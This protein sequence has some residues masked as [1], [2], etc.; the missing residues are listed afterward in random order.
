MKGIVSLAM[1]VF[2]LSCAQ[3]GVILPLYASTW[4]EFSVEWS[5]RE[6]CAADSKIAPILDQVRSGLQSSGSA[7][8]IPHRAWC[9]MFI[10]RSLAQIEDPYLPLDLADAALVPFE[11]CS[12][13]RLVLIE[14]IVDLSRYP[15]GFAFGYV[16]R[17][18]LVLDR[19]RVQGGSDLEF[20]L[21]ALISAGARRTIEGDYVTLD[22]E[23]ID[24]DWFR[25]ETVFRP[26][27][28]IV[29]EGADD[30]AI[31][32]DTRNGDIVATGGGRWAAYRSEAGPFQSLRGLAER[33]GEK[34]AQ[35]RATDNPDD[36]HR[37]GEDD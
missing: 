35:P 15:I 13:I 31:D 25:K 28:R 26:T 27:L 23:P 34:A 32:V 22:Y 12:S 17:G 7:F 21:S 14:P 11:H 24:E 4:P 2:G 36:A 8:S 30:F 6:T 19:Y 9:P 29:F 37:L 5:V 3:G 18:A 16:Y 20:V 1:I 33:L 10:H